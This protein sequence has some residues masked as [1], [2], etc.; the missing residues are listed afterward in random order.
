MIK[1]F[2]LKRCA[3][4]IIFG[5]GS[6]SVQAVEYFRYKDKNGMQV[7]NTYIPPEYVANGYEVITS[8]GQVLE[9]IDPAP[10]LE[11]LAE[12]NEK[13]R[14]AKEEAQRAAAQQE[15]DERLQKLYSHPDDA[16]R[17]LERKLNELDY[18]ISQK[19]GQLLV[20]KGKKEKNEEYAAS[21]ERSGRKVSEETIL[22]IERL[23]RQ[24]E[25]LNKQIELIKENK[26]IA[27]LKFKK[28]IDRM[29]ILFNEKRRKNINSK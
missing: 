22:D 13:K 17:A 1:F 26:A 23:S 2:K 19:R 21:R 11:E 12:R 25:D 20:L 5:L 10:T 18:Q 16:R 4:L 7:I 8:Q 27:R 14:L 9:V 3:V 6:L 28:D 29:V 24:I 15:V